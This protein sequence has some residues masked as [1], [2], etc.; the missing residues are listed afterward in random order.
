MTEP[1]V[2]PATRPEHIPEKFWD[3]AAGVVKA[4]DLAKSYTE[5]ERK[6]SGV[7]APAAPSPLAIPEKP[8]EAIKPP[9][10]MAVVDAEIAA[11]A[12]TEET[13]AKFAAVGISKGR[14]ESFM[15][16]EKALTVNYE[17][18]VV[19]EVGGKEAYTA[20]QQWATESLPEAEVRAINRVLASGDVE[21]AKAAAKGLV[22]RFN[23][24]APKDP[25]LI[26]GSEAPMPSNQAF[27]NKDAM[28]TAMN[29]PRYKADPEFR[30]KVG[31]RLS[32]ST[33]LN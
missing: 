13:I 2:T 23:A 26:H 29:D 3:A 15:A 22:A 16:G 17:A 30:A 7:K 6:Q 28:F 11:G 25:Q 1:E 12:L 5:L 21:G 4:D 20:A 18:Q 14:I 33:F 9:I 8:P 10:D 31:A 24:E 32:L 19:E 27:K